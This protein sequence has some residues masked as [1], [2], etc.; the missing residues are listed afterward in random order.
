[1]SLE[2][3]VF[4]VD[5]D[6]DAR[7]SVC[8]LV[9]SMSVKAESFSSA[10]AF[11]NAY[12]QSR[13]GCLVTDFRMLGMSGIDL[14]V[15]L[16][17]AGH[18]LP[19]IIISGYVNVSSAVRAMKKGATNVLT[20]PYEQ[21]DLWDTISTALHQDETI[22]VDQAL[23]KTITE[24]FERLTNNESQVLD[25]VTKGTANKV[26]ARRLD[27]SVRTVEDR[28]KKIYGKLN[29]GSVAALVE[30]VVDHKH[31]AT[32]LHG[33]PSTDAAIID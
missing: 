4:V 9:R 13:S 29:V 33:I 3:T 8:A 22:R 18:R 15:R 2:P 21:Q 24:R 11:L 1:M 25:L 27:I 12:D 6:Q 14:L 10:E 17:Q 19:V 31:A 28:R 30:L 20:K 16:K 5:D 32:D 23:R 26:I 7:D